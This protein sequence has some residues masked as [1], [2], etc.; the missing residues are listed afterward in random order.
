MRRGDRWPF[1]QPARIGA[2]DMQQPRW[3]RQ[4]SPGWRRVSPTVNLRYFLSSP[5]L[6]RRAKHAT[7]GLKKAYDLERVQALT[8]CS[9]K[10]PKPIGLYRCLY[11][12][13]AAAQCSQQPLFADL[14][15]SLIP[16]IARA[17]RPMPNSDTADGSGVAETGAVILTIASLKSPFRS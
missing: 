12:N 4:K 17:I 13:A 10:P 11:A 5:R 3:P 15:R 8:L 14:R 6:S 16:P 9:S 7:G 1:Q 2:K